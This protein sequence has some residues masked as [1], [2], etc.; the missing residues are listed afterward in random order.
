VRVGERSGRAAWDHSHAREN[1]LGERSALAP[2]GFKSF[3]DYKRDFE[4]FGW[5]S[6]DGGGLVITTKDERLLGSIGCRQNGIIAGYEVG[7]QIYRREDRGKGY[8]TDAL[9]HFT[10]YMFEW[11]D[12]PRLYLFIDPENEPSVAVA[13]AA[14]YTPEGVM[15][16]AV[17]ARGRYR[18]LAVYGIVR[19]EIPPS[20]GTS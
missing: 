4:K 8:M 9:S 16:R 7:Y 14:G 18:D 19:E 17:F 12:I 1:A 15:R 11:K 2:V 3:V 13:R 5:W 10:R 6:D 20:R